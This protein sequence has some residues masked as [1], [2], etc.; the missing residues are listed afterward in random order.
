MIASAQLPAI[1]SKFPWPAGIEPMQA[2]ANCGTAFMQHMA[3]A[4]V[5]ET[6]AEWL[7]MRGMPADDARALAQRHLIN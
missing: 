7:M 1:T 2:G 6:V 4:F 5:I 3:D